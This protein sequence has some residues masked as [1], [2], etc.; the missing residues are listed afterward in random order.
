MAQIIEEIEENDTGAN[1]DE[2]I[3]VVTF[4]VGSEEF[5]LPILEVHE[6]IRLSEI[7]KMPNAPHFVE[8]V[9]NL[10]SKVIPVINSRKRFSLPEGERTNDSRIIVIDSDGKRVGI[11]VDSVSEVLLLPSS[12]VEPPPDIIGGVDSD[13]ID[14]VGK[15]G[16]RLLIL[17]NLGKVLTV[18]EKEQLAG[19]ADIAPGAE[20][21]A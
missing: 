2:M 20:L 13:F 7:T 3:Q 21:Q 19:V 9:I 16:D 17:L 1:N 4:H 5:S 8:G 6:I 10:R 14:G 18:K 15:L 11:I 12:S